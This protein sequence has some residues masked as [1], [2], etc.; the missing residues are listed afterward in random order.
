MFD[1]QERDYLLLWNLVQDIIF[2]SGTV[3]LIELLVTYVDDL[4]NLFTGRFKELIC[5]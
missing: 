4:T 5:K 1:G 2:V 3:A